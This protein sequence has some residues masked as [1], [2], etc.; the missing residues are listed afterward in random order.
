V[1]DRLSAASRRRLADAFACA[2]VFLVAT[3][4]TLTA[5][6]HWAPLLGALETQLADARRA[7]VAWTMPPPA[8]D[9]RIVVL[10]V[11][12]STL[13]P[14]PYLLPFDRG[15]LAD[16]MEA[17]A[18]AGVRAV[19]LDLFF[20]RPTEP[21]KDARLKAVLE[22][23]PAPV[24]VSWAEAGQGLDDAEGA[25]LAAY[26]AGLG[27]GWPNLVKDDRD[28]VVRWLDTRFG[29]EGS[30]TRLA[31]AAA[32]A[33]AVGVP[34]SPGR[35]LLDYRLPKS[36]ETPAFPV[37]PLEAAALMPPAWLAGKIVLVGADLAGTDVHDVPGY[38]V[39]TVG[40]ASVPGVVVHAHALA[41]L[42][43]GREAPELDPWGRLVFAAAVVA[44]GLATAIAAIPWWARVVLGAA[45]VV[46]VLGA[47]VVAVRLGGPP[48]LPIA[49]PVLGYL[50]AFAGGIAFVGRR[51]R[52]DK[53]FIRD[54]FAQYVAPAVVAELEAEPDALRLGGDRLEITALFSD[55]AGFTEFSERM[56]PQA[57]GELLN[58]YFD[59]LCDAV[60][61]HGGTIDKFVGD[62][63]VALF[64]A[65]IAKADHAERALACALAIDRFAETF[66]AAETARG[67]PFG[68]TR[69]GVHT[70]WATVGN[71]G[72]RVRFNYTALGD[73]MNAASRLEGANKTFGTRIAL[74]ATTT[75]RCPGVRVRAIGDILLKGKAEPMTVY[76]PATPGHDAVLWQAYDWAYAA[77]RDGDAIARS[78]FTELAREYPED[79]PSR[80]HAQRLAQGMTGTLIKLTEK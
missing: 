22:S 68:A 51:L 53:R 35:R 31:L 8:Q 13:G 4:L 45:A 77:L 1:P 78:A 42:L 43:D 10:G 58:R 69:I 61:E 37:Y 30:A 9:D 80:L 38:V 5:P 41:Q 76:E 36:S 60:V 48:D 70:G 46:A 24:V 47:G 14:Y 23:F 65:P 6:S 33:E 26:A 20:V 40:R 56:D 18:R 72:G 19:G 28:R 34:T 79:G 57:L 21:A 44:A 16:A 55:V 66:R 52:R 74:S 3:V 75:A 32:L 73:T 62:A 50:G 27:K 49:T 17:L 67:V 59:G 63:I 11:R 64:G 2:A 54:A 29:A 39:G 7:L 25:W 12:L 15:M 71:F